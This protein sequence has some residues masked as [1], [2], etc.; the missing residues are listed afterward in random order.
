[1]NT[2]ENQNDHKTPIATLVATFINDPEYAWG[3]HCNIAMACYDKGARPHSACNA[4]AALFLKLLTDGKVDT[5]AHPAYQ[6]TQH[7]AAPDPAPAGKLSDDQLGEIGAKAASGKSVAQP[8]IAVAEGHGRYHYDEPARTAFAAAVREAVEKEHRLTP[9]QNSRMFAVECQNT[10]YKTESATQAEKIARLTAELEQAHV[11]AVEM[12]K[13]NAKHYAELERLRQS[14]AALS[15]K[16]RVNWT[17]HTVY[18][19][20]QCAQQLDDTLKPAPTAEEAEFEKAYHA[21]YPNHITEAF[22]KS[23]DGRYLQTFMQATFNGW[24]LARAAKEGEK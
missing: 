7:N 19:S 24:K 2:T 11:K 3:W 20:F 10:A 23:K 6:Q 18:T 21:E 9:D 1:M 14:L 5:T 17:T 13:L 22:E 4:G 15:N 12:I 16:W 8:T